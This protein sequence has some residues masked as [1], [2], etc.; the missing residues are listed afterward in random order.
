MAFYKDI[1][2]L[3]VTICLYFY[4]NALYNT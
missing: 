3:I 1:N 2:L 4:V